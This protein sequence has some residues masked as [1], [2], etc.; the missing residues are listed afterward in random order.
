[1]IPRSVRP[2]GRRRPVFGT[3]QAIRH[4]RAAVSILSNR[5]GRAAIPGRVTTLRYSGRGCC[6]NGLRD[7]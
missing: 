2:P 5:S 4:A 1:M 3:R 7:P 6:R